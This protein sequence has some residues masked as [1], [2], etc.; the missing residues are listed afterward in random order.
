LCL[1]PGMGQG[2]GSSEAGNGIDGRNY[3]NLKKN[4]HVALCQQRDDSNMKSEIEM[5][6]TISVAKYKE[7]ELL[8]EQAIGKIV[9]VR[10]KNGREFSAKLLAVVHDGFWFINKRGDKWDVRRS[11][12]DEFSVPPF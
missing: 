8:F 9:Y 2:S 5:R 1:L 3:V 6:Q 11:N 7:G 12:V 4:E 10:P